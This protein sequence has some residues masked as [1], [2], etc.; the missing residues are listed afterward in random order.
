MRISIKASLGMNGAVGSRVKSQ[1]RPVVG[2][3]PAWTTLRGSLEGDRVDL[4]DRRRLLLQS[5][6]TTGC[7][8]MVQ[9]PL[10]AFATPL[11]PLGRIKSTGE[12]MTGLS[13]EEVKDVLA[14]DLSRRKYF[15]TG[16]L[17]EAIFDDE[18]RF[19]DPTNDIVGLSRYRKALGILFDPQN[20]VLTLNTIQVKND[21]ESSQEGFIEARWILG[22]YLQLPWRPYI[23]PF[24][25]VSRYYTNEKG[26][27]ALQSQ[28]WAISATRALIETFTPG[29]WNHSSTS[30]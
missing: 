12:K 5:C 7:I 18:C 11:A 23:T 3:N 9:R 30:A 26:L 20:S 2:T 28:T 22:G 6:T 4:I 21:D 19:K 17:T 14:E 27:I 8:L 24:E 25:G 13:L 10:D 16:N 1:N 15:I 29:S